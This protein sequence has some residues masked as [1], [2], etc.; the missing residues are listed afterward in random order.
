MDYSLIAVMGPSGSG[1]SS[2]INLASGSNLKVGSG[3]RSC[4]TPVTP[5]APFF[6]GGRQV[7]LLDTPGFDDTNKSDIDVLEEIASYM[8]QTYKRGR[9]FDGILYFYSIDG[10]I[11]GGPTSRYVKVFQNLCGD[12][13]LASVIVVTNL[14]GLLADQELGETRERELKTSPEFFQPLIQQGARLMRHNNTVESAHSIVLSL[15]SETHRQEKLAI[16]AEIVDECLILEETSAAAELNCDFDALIR[17]LRRRVEKEKLAL[18]SD[19][20]EERQARQGK[21][22]RINS[23]IQELEERKRRIDKRPSS[24]SMHRRFLQWIRDIFSWALL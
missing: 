16:Q 13:A 9:L 12:D 17:N 15:F 2:F 11:L 6:L 20:V 5:T 14:W 1:K 18:A 7:V 10:R 23:Q 4:T 24:I 22:E 3:L 19:D 8:S 21:M